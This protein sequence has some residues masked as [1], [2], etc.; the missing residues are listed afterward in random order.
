MNAVRTPVP[1]LDFSREYRQV[2]EET[3]AALTAVCDAQQ[4]VLGP[5]VARFEQAAS[6]LCGGTEA[7]GCSSGTDALWLA[8][9]ATG[10]RPGDRVLTSPFSFF[11]T[12]SS[13]LRASAVPVFADIE[14][15][16]F[17]LSAASAAE[18]AEAS[19]DPPRAVLPVHLYGQPAD[20]RAF[21]RLADR[22][23]ASLVED[24]AQ[25][26]GAGWNGIAAGALGDSAAFSFYPTKNLSAFGDAGLATFQ[27]EAAATHARVLRSHGMRQKYLHSELGWN[28][29]LDSVQ[30]AVLEVKLRYIAAWNVQRAQVA[31]RYDALFVASGLNRPLADSDGDSDGVVLPATTPGAA[32][33]WHQYVVRVSA[34]RRDAL[35]RF[36]TARQIGTEVYYPVPLH[37]QQALAFLGYRKGEFPQAEKA[38]AQVL[39]LPIFPSLTPDEQGSVVGS[40][41]EFFRG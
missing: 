2:R 8:L 10:V 26:F 17:N 41:L 3:L 5:A 12:A 31:R 39:A 13:I 6:A 29:R 27:T 18:V 11:A 32:H 4:F 22:Y 20:M 21:R 25:A 37:L 14:P 9:A 28:A 19:P 16:S 38:S 24:A 30:A 23:G 36:L 7:V 34:R 40:I 35:R 1:F 15:A 33:V